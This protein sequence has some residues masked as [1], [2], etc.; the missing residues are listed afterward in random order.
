MPT[1]A[2][3]LKDKIRLERLLRPEIGRYNRDTVREF[4]RSLG[5]FNN[6]P[7]I[8]QRNSELASILLRHYERVGG[9]FSNRI[10]PDLSSDTGITSAETAAIL[11]A[12]SQFYVGLAQ[13]RAAQI[14]KTT[15]SDARKALGLAQPP[16]DGPRLS[17]LEVAATAGGILNVQ[18]KRRLST[19]VMTETQTIAEAAKATEAEILVGTIPSVSG[20]SPRQSEIN[21][22]WVS[23]G[24]DIVRPPHLA[25]DGQKRGLNIPF[26]VGGEELRWPG[27]RSLGATLGN[28]INCRCGTKYDTQ[29]IIDLRRAA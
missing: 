22:E 16:T 5:L 8:S 12:L 1:P 23:Q 3:D 13:S 18:L 7:N 11:A 14:N 27:D 17:Q 28:T 24:D 19:V 4:V 6:V 10:A 21:K 15:Q 2:Q 20:G 9:I 26:T 25:A 29:E